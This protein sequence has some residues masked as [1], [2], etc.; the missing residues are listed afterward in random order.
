MTKGSV[1]A[2]DGNCSFVE[3]GVGRNSDLLTILSSSG[4]CGKGFQSGCLSLGV[5]VIVTFS[6]V[7]SPSERHVDSVVG[8]EMGLEL[9]AR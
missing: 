9:N 7:S 4:R 3:K 1:G 2:A 8:V 5:S 6:H